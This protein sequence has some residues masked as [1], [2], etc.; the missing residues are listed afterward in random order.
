MFVYWIQFLQPLVLFNKRFSTLD[1]STYF[2]PT[3]ILFLSVLLENEYAYMCDIGLE[4]FT[5]FSMSLLANMVYG[6]IFVSDL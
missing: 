2:S 1:I 3:K 6:W 4:N 5:D